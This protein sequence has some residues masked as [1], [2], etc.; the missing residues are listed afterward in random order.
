[1]TSRRL[2]LFAAALLLLA[3]V[4]D[5]AGRPDAE[6]GPRLWRAIDR[7]GM[8]PTRKPWEDFYEYANGRWLR[9]TE[10]PP[11]KPRLYAITL[12]DDQNRRVLRQ[13]LEEAAKGP[14]PEKDGLRGKV[15][16]FYRS[17]MD[18]ARIEAAGADPLK[19]EF[20]RIDAVKDAAGVL[21]ALARLH[22]H[23]VGAGFN[24]GDTPDAKNSS[25]MI[26]IF[27]QGGLGLPDRDY[28]LKED[29]KTR[30]T[31][32]AYVEHVGKMFALLGEDAATAERHAKAVLDFETRLAKASRARVDLRDPHLN[33]HLMSRA[34]F[35]KETPGLDWGPYFAGLGLAD[36][37]EIN[38]GQPAFLQE[39][40][41]V[42]KEVPA[43]DW[44]TYLRWHLLDGY[45]NSL[46]KPFAA[47]DFHFKGTVLQGIPRDRPRWERV[48]SATDQMLGE[49]LGQLYVEKAFPPA[50][51][52][53]AEELVKNVKAALRERLAGLDWM[54]PATRQQAIK[55]LD[56]ITV[57]IGYPDKW[58]DYSGLAVGS[59]VYAVNVLAAK[60]FDVRYNL[61]K[62]GKPV[63]RSEWGMTPPTVNA[64]YN[65]SF[66]EIVFP[67]GILQPPFF[68][69]NADDAVNYGAI[70][71]VIGHELTHGFDDQG[72]KFDAAGN[73]R[74]WWQPQDE[75][76]YKERAAKMAKQYDAY[77][78]LEGLHINGKLTLGENIADL[79]GLRIAYLA[80][81]KARQGNPGPAEIDGFTPEQRFFLSYAQAWRGKMRP[82]ALRLMVQTNPH[83]PPNFRVLGP[84]SNM[85]E[86][87]RA[88]GA[89]P[90]QARGRL[91]PEPVEIW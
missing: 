78:P 79:G 43:E 33:Y 59:D 5:A 13:V 35:E 22:L 56:A 86:F 70:G 14:G 40:G 10:I 17:G 36:L 81:Q 8:D 73:L 46:S 2:A 67:A 61:A 52:A 31:R 55:K 85:P 53:R 47:E 72:R 37:K 69:P 41:K 23:E 65:P 76:A 60:E 7:A 42:V 66:N 11:D 90:E 29:E 25:R 21:P 71:M 3:P 48:V 80:L 57:K 38:V 26:A 44:R 64:Y 50:A 6:R 51:K 45:A 91:N 20:A 30:A 27:F 39:F 89:T 68:D 62:I 19:G 16:A 63:D 1:V 87:F 9:A 32:A 58:R 88:F 83:S 34:D 49:A 4:P 84:L 74:D 77:A 15:G 24:F 82:E 28:Y 18:E 54:T 75:V 12:L